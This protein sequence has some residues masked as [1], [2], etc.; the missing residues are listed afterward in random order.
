MHEMG[1]AMQ[2][3]EIAVNSIPV[4]FQGK[5]V[6]TVNLKVGKL[7][8]IVPDSLQFCYDIVIRETLLAG[9]KL[10]I[11]EIPVKARCR[12][13]HFEWTIDGPEFICK[14]CQ[15]GAIDIIAGR[16]LDIESIEIADREILDAG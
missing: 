15:S 4:N 2:I 10:N 12:E 7:S 3:V 5:S 9:S 13:C 16:E 1:I 6:E 11:E 14:N 8:A